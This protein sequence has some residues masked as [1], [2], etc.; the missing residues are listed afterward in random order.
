MR[1]PASGH[2]RYS[3]KAV[4]RG[5][6]RPRQTRSPVHHGPGSPSENLLLV[7][8]LALLCRCGT[9]A[10]RFSFGFLLGSVALRFRLVLL[11]LALVLEFFFTEHAA[12][13]FLG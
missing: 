9:T 6:T 2:C 4:G 13:G 7:G 12:D 8:L 1:W 10:S 3:V 5:L 11:S